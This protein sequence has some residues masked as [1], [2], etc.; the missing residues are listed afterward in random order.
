MQVFFL[1]HSPKKKKRKYIKSHFRKTK[2]EDCLN[3]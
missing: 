2:T 3:Q 1:N